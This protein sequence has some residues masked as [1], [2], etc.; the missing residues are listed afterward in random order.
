MGA[1]RVKKSQ[2]AAHFLL[3]SVPAVILI[4]AAS[5]L[6]SHSPGIYQGSIGNGGFG[7]TT[8]PLCFSFVGDDSL[9]HVLLLS[10]PTNWATNPLY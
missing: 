1:V 2:K 4:V 5:S 7:N 10:S 3:L 9:T 6:R 8:F